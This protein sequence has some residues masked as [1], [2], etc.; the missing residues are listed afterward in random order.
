MAKLYP[1]QAL[2]AVL[3]PILSIYA[4]PQSNKKNKKTV[5]A[6]SPIEELTKSVSADCASVSLVIPF[7][8]FL[9]KTL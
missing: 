8:K 6:L 5:T 7:S 1:V 4:V 9:S 3:L 2:S